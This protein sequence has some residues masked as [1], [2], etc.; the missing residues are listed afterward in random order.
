VTLA[1]TGA[2]GQLGRGVVTELLARVPAAEL[3]LLTRTPDRLADL[4]AQGADVHRADLDEPD[5][6][7]DALAGVRRLLLISTDALDRRVMQH[8]DALSAAVAAGVE[9]V[10]YTSVVS[11]VEGNPAAVVETHGQTEEDLRAA[12]CAWTLLR[13]NLYAEYQGPELEAAAATGQVVHNRGDGAAA[14][15]SRLDCAAVAA[16]VLAGDGH[17]GQAYDVT[18]PEALSAADLA[19][20]Y[21]DLCGRPVE[22]V[23]VDD[24]AFVAALAGEDADGHMQ[25]GAR[26]VASFGR[27]IREGWFAEVSDVVERLTGRAPRSVRDVLAAGG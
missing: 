13:N 10:I 8:R 11:P 2:S 16:A 24:D 12:G 22:A 23:A 18:G 19:A 20:L 7:P 3:R 4:A 6:L 21:A 1:V 17:D 9:R 5:G 26:L 27:A 25:Y 15:V 14:Y